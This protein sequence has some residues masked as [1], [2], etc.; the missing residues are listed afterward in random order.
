MPTFSEVLTAA[1]SDFALNGYD[2]EMRL[3]HWM[4]EIR[5]AAR[6]D[7]V[8]EEQVARELQRTL[9]AVYQREVERGGLLRANPAI[10]RFTFDRVKPKLRD[11][12]SRRTLASAS[13]IR[14]NREAKVED[15][16]RRFAGW[17]TSIPPGGS[18]AIRRNPVKADIRRALARLPFEDR[19]VAVDQGHKFASNLNDILV[20]DAG[21]IAMDWRHHH[22]NNPRP[23]H[24]A[25]N[26]LIY[27]IRGCWAHEQ[28]LVK[29]GDAGYYD[30]VTKPAEEPMCRCT[31]KAIFAISRLPADMITAKGRAE[32][33]RIK[34]K[35]A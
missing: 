12:L 2:S 17:G 28:G 8:P 25:R 33:A 4:A 32:L 19:R 3:E 14:L 5:A 10:G 24:I 27:L 9:G 30:E 18:E 21:A 23:D 7:L 29:P 15:T 13:L 6:R 22:S 26:G 35:A 20:T 34:E 11:E 1:V 16:V 31:A